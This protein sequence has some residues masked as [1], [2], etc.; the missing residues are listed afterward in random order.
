MLDLIFITITIGFFLIAI[1]YV[2]ACEKLGL[3][4]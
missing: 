1:A 3:K 2:Y 4:G